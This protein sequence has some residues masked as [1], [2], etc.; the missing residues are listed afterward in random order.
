[1]AVKFVAVLVVFFVTVSLAL[2]P[3]EFEDKSRPGGKYFCSRLLNFLRRWMHLMATPKELDEIGSPAN[4]STAGNADNNMVSDSLLKNNKKV[5][6]KSI[7]NF[8]R[9]LTA[10]KKIRR[11][12]VGREKEVTAIDVKKDEL[13]KELIDEVAHQRQLINNLTAAKQK[14]DKIMENFNIQNHR[15]LQL[16]DNVRESNERMN[17]SL[18]ECIHKITN[19]SKRIDE[20]TA[21]RSNLDGTLNKLR[22]KYVHDIGKLNETIGEVNRNLTECI[23]K[24]TS[25]YESIDKLAAEKSNLDD[26]LNCST[27]IYVNDSE[28][29]SKTIDNINGNLTECIERTT[30]QSELIDKL[31]I[32]KSNLDNLRITCLNDIVQL[33]K[34]IDKVKGNLTECIDTTTSQRKSIGE[35]INEKNILND[36]LDDLEITCLNDIEQ[37]NKIIDKVNGSL[38]ERIDTTTSQS[39]SID[40]LTNE[41]SKLN[42]SF[43]DLQTTYLKDI[44][45][46]KKT[47][48]KVNGSLT[49]CIDTTTSQRKSIDE[50]INE[51]NILNDSLDDLE[52]TCLNDIE[53]LNKIIDKVNGSLTECIDTTTSQSELVDKLTNEKSNR[54]DTLNDLRIKYVHDIKQANLSN[55]EI[56]T[57]LTRCKIEKNTCYERNLN[58]TVFRQRSITKQAKLRSHIR[59]LTK[60][61]NALTK[62]FNELKENLTVLTFYK[63]AYENCALHKQEKFTNLKHGESDETKLSECISAR[64][65]FEP[66]CVDIGNGKASVGDIAHRLEAC[67]HAR[68]TYVTGIIA[69]CEQDIKNYTET[70]KTAEKK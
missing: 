19:Q 32:E 44:V 55:D 49:E 51:K 11:G 50:L 48:D 5:S 1:M 3:I 25:R 69:K 63:S 57:N 65:K 36:S 2:D 39:K 8:W 62:A 60:N 4:V 66:T 12:D 31:A 35:L 54:N 17:R 70:V 16:C 68:N 21:E 61:H 33:N 64:R 45:Q 34:T 22:I 47:I 38:T 37:L 52:I 27:I 67:L 43:H 14:L 10:R 20:L 40:K 42:N 59:D 41:K 6:P 13:I 30:F 29:L 53:Q 15:Q 9:K 18:T 26:T 46:L 28:Q 23:G 7:F 58:L 56:N 24:S